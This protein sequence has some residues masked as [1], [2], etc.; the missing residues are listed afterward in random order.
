MPLYKSAG[1]KQ[2]MIFLPNSAISSLSNY[3]DIIS[4]Y[5]KSKYTNFICNAVGDAEQFH[6]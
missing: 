3:Q 5:L 1:L 6:K 2:A 4:T